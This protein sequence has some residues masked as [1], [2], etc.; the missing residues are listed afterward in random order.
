MITQRKLALVGLASALVLCA[1]LTQAREPVSEFGA[2]A[3]PAGIT[4]QPMGLAQGYSMNKE[5]ATILPREQIVFADSRGMSLYTRKDGGMC[6]PDCGDFSPYLAAA[7]AKP[8]GA[9]SLVKRPDGA[10]QWALSGKAVYTYAQDE[11]PGSV[12][13]NSPKRYGRGPSVGTRGSIIG[14]IAP[15]KPMPDGWTAAMLYPLAPDAFPAGFIAREVED[16]GGL[17]LTTMTGRTI[18]ALDGSLKQEKTFCSSLTCDWKPLAAPQLASAKGDFNFVVR[19]DG[20][21]QWT[22][23]GRPLYTFARD[24]AP[25]EANGVARAKEVSPAFVSRF[26]VP[27]GVTTQPTKKLGR[28]FAASAGQTIYKR[29]GFIF[30]S[31]SGHNLRRGDTVRPAVGRDLGPNPRCKNNCDAWHPFLAPD[32]AQPQGYWSVYTREDGKKQWAYQG[33]AL[34]TFDGDRRPG[35]ILGNDTF[36]LALSHDTETLVD[37][38]TPYDWPTALYWIVAYP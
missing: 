26:F 17:V 36:D 20:I 8:A 1:A 34:W 38:G 37:I 27:E 29:N 15:D 6:E 13:G 7:D 9:W 16:A 23:K 35:D 3:A 10:R 24:A 33:Y 28:V 2:L 11:D 21:R 4:F 18:Y 19:D 25:G 22:F 31:G 12:A 30:Q 5:S 32:D 14:P